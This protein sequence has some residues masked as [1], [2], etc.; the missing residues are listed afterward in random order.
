MISRPNLPVGTFDAI[1]TPT[2]C[3]GGRRCSPAPVI[4]RLLL[5]DFR[6]AWAARVFR[7]TGSRITR[8][9]LYVRF[10]WRDHFRRVSGLGRSDHRYDLLARA[11]RTRCGRHHRPRPRGPRPS[12]PPDHRPVGSRRQQPMVDPD[13]RP[14]RWSSTAASTTT[15]SCG[16]SSRQ[17]G[18]RFFSTSDT[19]VILKAYHAWGDEAAST[20][21][22]GMFA[23]AIHRARQRPGRPRAATASAS[24]RSTYAEIARTAA[25]RLHPAGAGRR[26][27]RRHRRSTRSR[28]TTT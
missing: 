18:Y 6:A 14:D 23:F 20:A 2:K 27:R 28:C 21:S 19:E 1:T 12:P 10:V 5:F 25:I 15:R 17:L 16:P 8:G 3:C 22:I 13:A 26:R 9:S 11:A 24:S 7:G 4:S